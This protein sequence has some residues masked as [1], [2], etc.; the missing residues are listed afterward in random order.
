MKRI[1][2][3]FA[4]LIFSNAGTHDV[5]VNPMKALESERILLRFN[6]S[7]SGRTGMDGA[8][9]VDSIDERSGGTLVN[10]YLRYRNMCKS[11]VSH[12]LAT[13]YVMHGAPHSFLFHKYSNNNAISSQVWEFAPC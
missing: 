13:L 12:T 7:A 1:F 8:Q 2:H 3:D 10:H 6:A 11:D 5:S 4:I 9:A